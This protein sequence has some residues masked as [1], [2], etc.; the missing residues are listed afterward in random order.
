[1][2]IILIVE[3]EMFIRQSAEWTIEDMGHTILLA[4]DLDSAL[5]HLSGS[6]QIDALFVDIRLAAS[7]FGGYDV[8]NQAIKLH[9]ALRVLYTS[10]S[11]LSADMTE[12]FVG[13]GQFLQKPYSPAQ[14][15]HSIG[16]LLH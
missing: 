11:C 13:G 7:I 1:M 15:E 14:L 10:G 12:L 5:L 9:P 6:R 8:A 16:E 4:M 3:D 2:A